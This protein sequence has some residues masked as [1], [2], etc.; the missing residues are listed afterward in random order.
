MRSVA[1]AVAYLRDSDELAEGESV[2]IRTTP[3][4]LPNGERSGFVVMVGPPRADGAMSIVRMPSAGGFTA[5]TTV[6]DRC[7]RHIGELNGATCDCNGNVQ[8]AN[9]EYLHAIDLIP[10]IGHYE[11]TFVEQIIVRLALKCLKVENQCCPPLHPELPGVNPPRY[12]EIAGVR[13][14]RL[15]SV[16]SYV[17]SRIPFLSPFVVASA[18]RRAGMKLPRT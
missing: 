10:T 12:D 18:L 9:G 5:L 7:R 17:A 2:E 8:L 3:V 4:V 15:K 1:D 13:V 6:G 14:E 11:L 16:Q